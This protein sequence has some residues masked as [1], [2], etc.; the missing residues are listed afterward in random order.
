MHWILNLQTFAE[1]YKPLHWLW[2][3]VHL[4]HYR[5]TFS[6]HK[7]H[8]SW[9]EMQARQQW[10]EAIRRMQ[11]H[12][13]FS[14]FVA[15]KMVRTRLLICCRIFFV[16]S[17]LFPANCWWCIQPFLNILYDT[18]QQRQLSLYY[19]IYRHALC[20]LPPGEG[21]WAAPSVLFLFCA[22][23]NC[24]WI[25]IIITQFSNRNKQVL[26]N[27]QCEGD[28]FTLAL[29]LLDIQTL[30]WQCGPGTD[31][32]PAIYRKKEKKSW[33]RFMILKLRTHIM[34]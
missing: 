29:Y 33:N 20:L 11:V 4:N 6:F 2:R 1:V 9:H 3:G 14:A 12:T 25:E 15:L 19:S 8:R 5:C 7:C 18:S 26:W 13:G 30:E 22:L 32:R 31:S 24:T 21:P 23:R 17:L 34:M 28:T 16:P 10:L 27:T